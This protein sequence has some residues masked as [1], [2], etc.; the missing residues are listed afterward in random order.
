MRRCVS[1]AL[2]TGLALVLSAQVVQAETPAPGLDFKFRAGTTAGAVHQDLRNGKA[3]GLGFGLTFPTAESGTFT[4]DLGYDVLPGTGYDALPGKDRTIYYEWQGSVIS[5]YQ[6]HPLFVQPAEN[7]GS[8]DSRKRSVEGFS[9]RLGYL[10]AIPA[11]QNLSWQ[12]GLTAE[13]YKVR[14]QLT[15]NIVPNF[16]AADGSTGHLGPNEYEGWAFSRERTAIKPGA[17]AGLVYQLQEDSKLEL[18]L[19]T[20]GYRF[21]DY[22]PLGY[23]GQPGRVFD[24][25]GRGCVVEF[26]YAVKL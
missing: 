20:V 5:S 13:R 18:N 26:V 10:H 15:G 16:I 8:F 22:T 3:F 2:E 19:R 14:S 23:S 21:M 6:G 11:I 7:F 24:Q 25:D 9:L 1:F 17:Y 12:A 4:V